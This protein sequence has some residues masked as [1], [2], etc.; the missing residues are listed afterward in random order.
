MGEPTVV[1]RVTRPLA[2]LLVAVGMLVGMLAVATGP[3]DAAPDLTYYHLYDC[4]GPVGTPTTFEAV[5]VLGPPRSHEVNSTSEFIIVRVVFVDTGSVFFS[6]RGFEENKVPT[7][8]CLMF[9]PVRLALLQVTFIRTPI[10][11]H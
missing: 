5:N 3:V 10:G 1:R 11:E 6:L 7:I 2:S 4:T 9:H 8:T